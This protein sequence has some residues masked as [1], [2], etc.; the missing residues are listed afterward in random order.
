MDSLFITIDSGAIAWSRS[1]ITRHGSGFDG[2]NDLII[3][4][5]S[6]TS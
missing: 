1:R 4:V 6:I 2:S 3:R 5:P